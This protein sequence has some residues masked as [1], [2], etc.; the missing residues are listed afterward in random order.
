MV[1]VVERSGGEISP[2][3]EAYAARLTA[4]AYAVALRHGVRGSFAD[5]ELDLWRELRAVVRT[6]A[7]S[8]KDET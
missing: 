1:A 8:M 6:A 2:E 5:L 3:L 7:E 4:A